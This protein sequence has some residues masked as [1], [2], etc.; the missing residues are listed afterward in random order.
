LEPVSTGSNP[1][2]PEGKFPNFI[3]FEVCIWAK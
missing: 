3:Y 2:V 1:V